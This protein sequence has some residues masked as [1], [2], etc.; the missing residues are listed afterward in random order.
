[1]GPVGRPVAG[2]PRRQGLR[3]APRTLARA[4]LSVDTQEPL[5]HTPAPVGIHRAVSELADP[6]WLCE[7]L[8]HSLT[9]IGSG[10]ASKPARKPPS[11]VGA[12]ERRPRSVRDSPRQT[13]RGVVNAIVNARGGRGV[14][15]RSCSTGFLERASGRRDR[16]S[17]CDRRDRAR[18]AHNVRKK[19]NGR[20]SETGRSRKAR[21]RTRS[22][23]ESK[24]ARMAPGGPRVRRAPRVRAGEKTGCRKSSFP[25]RWPSRA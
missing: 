1:M 7:R 9:P 8:S 16:A 12:S 25:I 22:V 18:R 11:V 21:G 19:P 5:R 20:R 4:A 15:R 23:R 14:G 17:T 3:R 6:G 24:R 13:V 10:P 2:P